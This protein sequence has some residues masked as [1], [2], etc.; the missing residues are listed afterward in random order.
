MRDP[1]SQQRAQSGFTLIE[2]LISIV[3]LTFGVLSLAAVYSQG[4]FYTSLSQY[5]Y[6]AEKKAEQAMEAI[7][8]ARDTG[9]LTWNQILNVSGV[10]G[11]D[12]G[13]FL[14]GPQP[15]LLPGPDGLVGA[16]SDVGSPDELVITGPGA[17]GKLGTADDS[18]TD[19][20]PWMKRTITI[21]PV[22]AET[23]LRQ[24]TIRVDYTVGKAKR[25]YTLISYISSFS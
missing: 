21:V 8:A 9:T 17:D 24:V 11:A 5:D 7:F 20:N 13:V 23:N 12:K 19:L 18:T 2:A 25:S 16:T 4:I 14:D 10:S 22:N 1:K 15:I 6:I 3:V